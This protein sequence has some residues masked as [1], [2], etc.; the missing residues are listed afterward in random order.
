MSAVRRPFAGLLAGHEGSC[1]LGIQLG[2]LTV[3]EARSGL[4]LRPVDWGDPHAH[5]WV[6]LSG[7][8]FACRCGAASEYEEGVHHECEG[9]MARALESGSASVGTPS[10]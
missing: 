5:D 2:I 8:E 10:H 7:G 9:L 4:G 6:R 1:L 3:N